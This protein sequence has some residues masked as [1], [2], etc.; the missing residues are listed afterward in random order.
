MLIIHFQNY[1]IYKLLNN[2]LDYFVFIIYSS[3]KLK[4]EKYC[5]ITVKKKC[6]Q[7][8]LRSILF[9]ILA[10][11]LSCVLYV[12]GIYS[13]NFFFFKFFQVVTDVS[14]ITIRQCI[15][16]YGFDN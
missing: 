11:Y 3:Y 2:Y 8:Q 1:F 15:Q 12:F 6:P 14:R 9:S 4:F 7:V 10:K 13:K 16:V 5:F